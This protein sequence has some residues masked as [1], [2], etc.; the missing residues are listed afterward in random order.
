MWTVPPPPAYE[1]G[2]DTPKEVAAAQKAVDQ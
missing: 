2:A 1:S